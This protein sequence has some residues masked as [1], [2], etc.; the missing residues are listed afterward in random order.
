[1][2]HRPRSERADGVSVGSRRIFKAISSVSLARLPPLLGADQASKFDHAGD[3]ATV[4]HG[5]P[6][7]HTHGHQPHAHLSREEK[8]EAAALAAAAARAEVRKRDQKMA[9]T[10]RRTYEKQQAVKEKLAECQQ[11]VIEKL[12]EVGNAFHEVAELGRPINT[13]AEWERQWALE[14]ARGRNREDE[15]EF[16]EDLPEV[17][18]LAAILSNQLEKMLQMMADKDAEVQNLES[19]SLASLTVADELVKDAQQSLDEMMNELQSHS[20]SKE[21][22]LN[23]MESLSVGLG[24]QASSMVSASTIGRAPDGT[25]GGSAAAA[26]MAASSNRRKSVLLTGGP[27]TGASSFTDEASKAKEAEDR[28]AEIQ[29]RVAM[30]VAEAERRRKDEVQE[31]ELRKQVCVI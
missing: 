25:P 10:A 18:T 1:V 17:E 6:H 23:R 14:K 16:E 5:G 11:Q 21:S 2:P 29:R 19:L 20:G 31:A 8:A 13:R 7:P 28:E 3:S 9:D 30:L 27:S 12:T 4:A 22:L 15:L 26:A 24:R